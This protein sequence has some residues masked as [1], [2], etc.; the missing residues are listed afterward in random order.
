MNVLFVTWDGPQVSYLETLFL[1]IFKR[2]KPYGFNFH[3]IQFSWAPATIVDMRRR[4]CEAS[5]F[6]YTAVPVIRLHVA[7]G[8][9]ITSLLGYRQIR[10]S[11]RHHNIDV[12]MARSTLPALSSLL[13]LRTGSQHLIFDAD[14]LPLDERVDFAGQSPSGLVYRLLRDVEAQ[15]VRKADV[16]LT[17]SQK[18]IGILYARAGAGTLYDKFFVVGNGRDS[19]LFSPG[20]QLER[21]RIRKRLGIGVEAP[22]VVYAGSLGPQYCPAAMLELFRMIRKTK[23]DSHFLVLTGSTNVM[24]KILASETDLKS[25]L[26]VMRLEAWEVPTYI[27]AADL[28]LS[29]RESAFSMQAVSPIK[30]GEYL[31]CGV[32]VVANVGIGDSHFIGNQ[33]GFLIDN[34]NS[35]TLAAVSKWFVNEVLPRR[36]DFRLKSRSVGLAHFSLDSCVNVYREAL[37]RIRDKS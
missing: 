28:G 19:T 32:P 16:I 29:F 9:L 2:L 30:I 13:A 15:A 23:P 1:P 4:A 5:G 33:A 14:G 21:Q 12:V 3:I 18:A 27:S 37:M 35:K 31:L 36:N 20:L 17:R 25:S 7:I 22:L 10:K 24:N 11:I 34:C 26:T 6:S 8:S